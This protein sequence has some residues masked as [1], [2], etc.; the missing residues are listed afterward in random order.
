MFF[1][2]KRPGVGECSMTFYIKAK[3]LCECHKFPKWG[4]GFPFMKNRKAKIDGKYTPI[5]RQYTK[6]TFDKKVLVTEA[7]GLF[8]LFKKL[9][10]N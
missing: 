4:K 2:T 7:A 10:S 5:R 3:V 6:A 1:Y 9:G 8:G